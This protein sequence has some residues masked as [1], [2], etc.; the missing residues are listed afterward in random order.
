MSAQLATTRTYAVK[1]HP[2]LVKVIEGRV[3]DCGRRGGGGSF[4]WCCGWLHS[5]YN[6]THLT[7]IHTQYPP[8]TPFFS[9][10]SPCHTVPPLLAPWSL[11]TMWIRSRTWGTHQRENRCHMPLAL[12]SG[13]CVCSVLWQVACCGWKV[14]LGPTPRRKL[15]EIGANRGRRARIKRNVWK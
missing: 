15:N 6:P 14:K 1:K 12:G 8:I 7:N 4:D 11:E 13:M 5:L 10:M 9:T 3:S 2:T